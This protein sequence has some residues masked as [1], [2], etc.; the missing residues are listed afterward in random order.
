MSRSSSCFGDETPGI[1]LPK[2]SYSAA[3]DSWFLLPD[4]TIR[5]VRSCTDEEFRVFVTT[6]T[7]DMQ[8]WQ[9]RD[10]LDS[11][12]FDADIGRWYILDALYHHRPHVDV[13]LFTSEQDAMLA[14]S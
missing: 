4:G 14:F 13:P 6:C 1:A 7:P 2:L 11:L 5:K 3:L 8:R 12:A 9:R 10:L